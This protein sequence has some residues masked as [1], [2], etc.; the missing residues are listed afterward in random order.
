MDFF[1]FRKVMSHMFLTFVTV[2]N[3]IV[4]SVLNI[5]DTSDMDNQ[6]IYNRVA[7]NTLF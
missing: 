4:T 5:K 3:V 6:I 1:I 7:K 2:K